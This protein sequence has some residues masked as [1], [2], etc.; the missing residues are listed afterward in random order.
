VVWVVVGATSLRTQRLG[1][2]C[3]G[4]VSEPLKRAL[5]LGAEFLA[6]FERCDET[7]SPSSRAA[8]I[9]Y[10]MSKVGQMLQ[11]AFVHYARKLIA[12]HFGMEPTFD[13]LER[14]V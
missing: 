9:G 11:M 3:N 13:K 8:S 4:D 6:R 10:V 12:K 1:R 7:E 14:M 5:Y 2:G